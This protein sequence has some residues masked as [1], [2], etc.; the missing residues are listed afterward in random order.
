MFSMHFQ[1]TRDAK[2]CTLEN[3]INLFGHW[4]FGIIFPKGYSSAKDQSS[5]HDGDLKK[6]TH[7]Q[8]G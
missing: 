1:S 6:I 4:S 7:S 3:C 2:V 5:L 8:N